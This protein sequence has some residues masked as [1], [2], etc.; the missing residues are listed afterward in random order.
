MQTSHLEITPTVCAFVYNAVSVCES[1]LEK[2]REVRINV[3]KNHTI[4][5]FHLSKDSLKKASKICEI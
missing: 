4:E 1:G 5:M 3:C 2:E